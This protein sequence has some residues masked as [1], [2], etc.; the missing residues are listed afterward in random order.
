M[1]GLTCDY[2]AIDTNVFGHLTNEEINTCRHIHKLLRVPGKQDNKIC[3]LVDAGNSI[4]S[5]Y[6]RHLNE[7][8]LQLRQRKSEAQ[9]IKYWLRF[10]PKQSV[11]VNKNEQLWDAIYKIVPE[12]QEEIDRIFIYVAFKKGRILLSNDFKHIVNRRDQLKSC[13]TKGFCSK[14]ADVMGSKEAYH[15]VCNTRTSS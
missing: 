10:A 11:T 13:Y 9:I 8:F 2:I 14:G 5:E 3:L 15:R 1:N 7:E 12:D 6:R 4:F